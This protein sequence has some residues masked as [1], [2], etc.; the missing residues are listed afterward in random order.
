MVAMESEMHF[1]TDYSP[2]PVARP[3]VFESSPVSWSVL[4]PFFNEREFI[5]ETIL[6]LARQ[7]CALRLVLIDNGSTDGGAAIARAECERLKLDYVI[8]TERTP[9]KVAALRRG[10]GLV[11]TPF[12]ATCDADT[13]YPPHYLAEAARLLERETDCVVAG[14]YYVA[15]DATP[16]AMMGVAHR[17]NRSAR[18]LPRQCHTGGAGQT[19]RTAALRAAGGFD[20][21][22]W[23]YVL[24]DH[25]VI[26]RVMKHGTM[27]YSYALWCSPS[28]RQR[29]RPS[30]RWTLLE[31]LMYSATAPWAGDW[32]F[33]RF[34]AERLRRRR[35]LSQCIREHAFQQMD[36]RTA[37]NE[38]H[39]G[40]AVAAPH[41]M[42]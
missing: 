36:D 16:E 14:A 32:F 35:L 37:E 6:S 39:E 1:D 10:L 18:M 34:L 23:N 31:R 28:P 19:F 15:P 29:D 26:H 27:R 8:V 38:R 11:R 17:I 25:E 42:C 2:A 30:I 3:A 9:G 4:L 7:T 22:L 33:Y 20:G 12:V 5:A 41:S 40:T 21:T 13:F 24:E